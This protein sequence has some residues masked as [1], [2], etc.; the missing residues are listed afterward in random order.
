MPL[1]VQLQH[2]LFLES[3]ICHPAM[4]TLDVPPSTITWTHFLKSLCL[5]VYLSSTQYLSL[6]LYMYPYIYPY[7][8]LC[9]CLFI[10][11]SLC[12]S[13]SV[14]PSIYISISL[15]LPLS[16]YLYL[17]ISI[18]LFCFFRRLMQLSFQVGKGDLWRRKVWGM[19]EFSHAGESQL[20]GILR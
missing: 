3:P 2:Q 15:S 5:S 11:L 19:L 1:R 20:P 4:Q 7:L 16:V 8:Y 13:A 10:C 18:Y 9:L 14:S 17:S 6:S 12:I